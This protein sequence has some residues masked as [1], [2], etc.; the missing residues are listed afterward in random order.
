MSNGNPYVVLNGING[1]RGV[2][3]VQPLR[4][5][6]LK[7]IILGEE[8]REID[9]QKLLEGRAFWA[10][11]QP[12]VAKSGVDVQSLAESGWG[13][14]FPAKDADPAV[15]EALQPLLAW[16]KA[17]AGDR[18]Y[19]FSGEKGFRSGKDDKASFVSRF[20]PNHAGP[21][22]PDLFPYYVLLVGS[23]EEIPYRFQYQLGVQANVGRIHFDRIADY[24]SYAAAVVRLERGKQTP[25]RRMR[26]FGVANTDDPATHLSAGELIQPLLTRFAKEPAG[27]QVD[28]VL[29]E[30][31]TKAGLTQ[32]LSGDQR[33]GLLFTASHGMEFDPGDP[34]Q[35]PHQGALLCQ[36]WPGPRAWRDKGPIPEAHYFAGSDLTAATDLSGMIAIM[37]ACYGLG[38]PLLDDF[39]RQAWKERMPIAER[40]FVA[41][42]AQQ[43][44]ARGALAVVGHVERAW[45]YSFQW[46]GD[47]DPGGNPNSVETFASNINDLLLGKPIGEAMK[48]FPQ[49]YAALATALLGKLEDA[50]FGVDID[51]FELVGLWTANN[52]ARGY[53]LLGDP[54]VRLVQEGAETPAS[55]PTAAD[56]GRTGESV[57]VV[58]VDPPDDAAVDLPASVEVVPE[59][60][61]AAPEAV[62]FGLRDTT[63]DIKETL[64]RAAEKLAD[65]VA[66][67]VDDLAALDVRTYTAADLRSA[68]AGRVSEVPGAALR[69]RT[70]I[71]IDGDVES[72][73]PVREVNSLLEEGTRAAT[74][75]DAQLWQIHREMVDVAQQNR[76]AFI[77][78]LAEIA[79]TLLNALT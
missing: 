41:G 2:Y 76:V 43:L 60:P 68:A 55:E 71:S 24:A 25:S 69:A 36:D 75:I 40:P 27:W 22:D 31:A 65:T 48:Y 45:S 79:G 30:S 47:R 32:M 37:F 4:L 51:P 53:V 59:P 77:K 64:R 54:A 6:S 26:F 15:R 20:M 35:V 44:L 56:A 62:D 11:E 23:P 5:S 78:A 34:R 42:L 39:A 46:P 61:T 8:K 19:E 21:I 13:V 66:T 3:G 57:P 17:Q 29:G 1:S 18:F 58:A 7:R 14:V 33:P 73:V 63:R 9:D 10:D 16:R 52:D 70:R 74:E 72:I 28:S 50:D 67:T 49:R 12:F 38:T